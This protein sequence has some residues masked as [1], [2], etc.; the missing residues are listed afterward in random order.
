LETI[1]GHKKIDKIVINT[2]SA[3]QRKAQVW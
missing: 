2:S 1:R 3:Q